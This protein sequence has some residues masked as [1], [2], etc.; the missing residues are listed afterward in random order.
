MKC[1]ECLYWQH[2]VTIDAVKT[3]EC[4]KLPPVVLEEYTAWPQISGNDWCGAF[5]SKRMNKHLCQ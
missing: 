5:L 2:T 3:G 1:D 4:R